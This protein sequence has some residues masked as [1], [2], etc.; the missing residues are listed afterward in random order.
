M[1]RSYNHTLTMEPVNE[2]GNVLSDTDSEISWILECEVD[3]ENHESEEDPGLIE[4]YRFEPYLEEEEGHDTEDDSSGEGGSMNADPPQDD[5][6]RL[7]NTSWYVFV[8]LT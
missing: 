4:P 8:F 5:I 3:S 1:V 6:G 7:E 2:E